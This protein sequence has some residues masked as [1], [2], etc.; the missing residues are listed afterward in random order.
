MAIKIIK[1]KCKGCTLC[2]KA[3]P[4]DALKIE[5]RPQKNLHIILNVVVVVNFGLIRKV[6]GLRGH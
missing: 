1:D 6:F 3:C 2:A 5:N 4:F